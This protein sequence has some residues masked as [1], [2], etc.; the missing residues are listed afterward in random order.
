MGDFKIIEKF[1]VSKMPVN[2]VEMT[3]NSEEEFELY[4]EFYSEFCSL[5]STVQLSVAK[6][7]ADLL[8]GY[9][10]DLSLNIELD[11]KETDFSSR[12]QDYLSHEIQEAIRNI[13]SSST[14]EIEL[15]YNCSSFLGDYS[16]S[17]S[18]LTDPEINAL[19]GEIVSMLEIDLKIYP[20]EMFDYF[21]Y[22]RYVMD[23][24][25]LIT[26]LAIYGKRNG[27]LIRGNPDTCVL[28]EAPAFGQW[29]P[30]LPLWIEDCE[31]KE[32][33]KNT[34]RARE[35]CERLLE[36]DEAPYDNYLAINEGV[37]TLVN[38]DLTLDADQIMEFIQII[39]ELATLLIMPNPDSDIF[40][41]NVFE[42]SSETGPNLITMRITYDGEA[43]VMLQQGPD[44]RYSSSSPK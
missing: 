41:N 27:K 8:C 21:D 39:S 1:H 6:A 5:L 33:E 25:T 43:S 9:R 19:M 12:E 3:F 35:L 28:T 13:T 2:P 23:H 30:L 17:S 14:I 15:C 20:D 36:W 44:E 31:I 34:P 4:L 29:C 32:P 40:M 24:E 11:G 38:I 42:D 10:S 26:D 18:T 37:L 16:L 7:C 22:V